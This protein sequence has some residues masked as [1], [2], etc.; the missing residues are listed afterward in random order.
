[1]MAHDALY[2]ALLEQLVGCKDEEGLSIAEL[3]ALNPD[4]SRRQL[5]Y[6]LDTLRDDG[7]V[8]R[9]GRGR[10]TRY[11]AAPLA[12][13]RSSSSAQTSNSPTGDATPPI[14]SIAFDDPAAGVPFGQTSLAVIKG[15]EVSNASRAIAR[16]EPDWIT[17]LARDSLLS[18]DERATLHE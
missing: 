5:R 8:E 4:A 14:E 1:M 12:V 13:A 7:L 6:R 9:T 15:L 17:A 2:E 10:A 16:Y 11:E 3:N 18:D